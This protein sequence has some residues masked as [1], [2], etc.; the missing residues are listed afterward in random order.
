LLGLVPI[1]GSALDLQ[2]SKVATE[3]GSFRF[4]PNGKDEI[5]ELPINLKSDSIQAA[6]TEHYAIWADMD[7]AH[8]IKYGNLFR[9]FVYAQPKLGGPFTMFTFQGEPTGSFEDQIPLVDFSIGD[10]VQ[11][12]TGSIRLPI[13]GSSAADPLSIPKWDKPVEVGLANEL[14]LP[15][16]LHNELRNMPIDID[17]IHSRSATRNLWD[18]LEVN[19]VGSLTLKNLHVEPRATASELV[20]KLRPKPWKAIGNALISRGSDPVD[21]TIHLTALYTT[22]GR[23]QRQLEI[24]VPIKFV[25]WPPFLLLVALAGTLLGCLLPLV[26]KGL[27]WRD[28]WQILLTAAIIALALEALAMVLK[29]NGSEFRVLHIELNPFQ[30]LPAALIGVFVGMTGAKSLDKFKAVINK[31]WGNENG[32]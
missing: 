26:A 12:E 27:T 32:H 28:R 11:I 7:E 16:P 4:T 6:A 1:C 3:G 20:L 23:P 15:L 2:L 19:Q 10:A 9:Y 14:D 30:E 31:F 22:P 24:D 13:F 17:E 8:A 25:P 18:V 21:D 29:D 5:R